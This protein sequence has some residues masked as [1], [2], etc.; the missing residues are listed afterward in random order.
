MM[1]GNPGSLHRIGQYAE[2][3]FID[4]LNDI[5]VLLR[6][7]KDELVVTSGGTES[8]NTALLGFTAANPHN[9]KHIISTHTEH[10]AT[11]ATL[12]RLE[13]SGYEVTYI[14]VNRFGEPDLDFL[15]RSIRNDTILITMTHTNNETGATL[16]ADRVSAIRKRKNP[17]TAIHLDCVQTL[18]KEPINFRGWGID[19]AS[20]SGHKIHC[21]KGVGLL[22]VR[23]GIR[24]LPLVTGGGQ[25]RGL[26]S[27]TES[28]WILHA[29]SL[30]LRS[31]YE[32]MND[33]LPKIV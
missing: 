26:R 28:P 23:K 5:S 9:G 6:V 19:L 18:G 29:F 13:K 12:E 24:I 32:E 16:P 30:A 25:Q 21:V 8:I 20:F 2:K 1:F 22:F 33:S 10:L 11:L 15:E 27:G 4:A 31:A 14:P 3:L 17:R 7:S